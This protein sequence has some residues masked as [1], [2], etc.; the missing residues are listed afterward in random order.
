MFFT[1]PPD[2]PPQA[3]GPAILLPACTGVTVPV[4]SYVEVTLNGQVICAGQVNPTHHRR[5]RR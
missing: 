1:P 2:P 4:R 5:Q 3:P